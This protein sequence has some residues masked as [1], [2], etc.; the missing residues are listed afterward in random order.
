[1]ATLFL[2]LL[3]PFEA[4]LGDRPLG[5]FRSN[6][7]QALLIYLATEAEIVH[8]REALMALLWPGLPFKSA[9]V[10]LRQ[11]L[12]RLRQAIPELTA[13]DGQRTVP[14]LLTG[15]QTVHLNPA[16]D[17]QLDLARFAELLTPPPTP[18][19]L[20]RAVALYRGDFIC[21][22]CLP[23]SAEFEKWSAARRNELRRR[24][25]GA[26][27]TLTTIH[28]EQRNYA[29]AQAAAQ[30]GIEIDALRE[31]AYRQ[32]MRALA[33][34]GQREA[35]LDQY[36]L[37][38]QRL[39][40]A[41]GVEPSAQTTALY[42]QLLNLSQPGLSRDELP[43]SRTPTAQVQRPEP[44]AQPPM[45]HDVRT[46]PLHNLPLQPTPFVGREEELTQIA[47]RLADPTCR[48]L[49]LVGP[50]GIG[51]TRLALQASQDLIEA[52]AHGVFVVSLATISTPDDL[53]AT[54]ASALD[55]PFYSEAD[56]RQQLLAYLREKEILLVL[57]N[58]EHL[59]RG[60][61]LLT[62][63]LQTAPRVKLLLTSRER[64]HLRWEWCFEVEGLAYP[65][66]ETIVEE[67]LEYYSAL[68]LFRLTARRIDPEFSFTAQDRPGVVRICRLVEGMPLG[69]ELAASW[70]RVRTCEQIADEIERNLNFL[71]TSLRNVPPRHQSARATFE[72]SWRMLSP[73]EQDLFMKLSVLRGFRREAAG[74][75]ADATRSMLRSL[76]DKSLLRFL[77]SGRYE[78]HELL[79]QYAEEKLAAL[80]HAQ[81]GAHDRHCAHYAAFLRRHEVALARAGAAETL[82]AIRSEIANIRSAWRWAVTHCR[83]EELEQ[84]LNGL[85]RYYL[86]AGPFQEGE[87]LIGMAADCVRRLV[88]TA[89]KP[90]R[91]VHVV[92]SKLLKEQARLLNSQGTY[93]QAIVVARE[94]IDRA[95]ASGAVGLE[96]AGHVQWGRALWC[97]GNHQAAQSRFE[98]ALGLTQ[99]ASTLENLQI[100]G[101]IESLQ[102]AKA[103][104]LRYLGNVF[105]YQ[106]DYARTRDCYQECLGIYREIGDRRGESRALNNLGAVYFFQGD[107]AGAREYWEQ[108][109][110]IFREIGDRPGQGIALVNLGLLYHHLSDDRTALEY[111]RRAFTIRQEIGDL[112]GQGYALTVLGHALAGLGQWAE[113]ADVYQDALEI[114][115]ELGQ[116][117]LALESLAGLAR[118]SLAQ[119]E[120]AQAQAQ[121][122]QILDHLQTGD[123]RGAEEPFRVYLTCY[124]V[125]CAT[126]DPRA[127]AVLDTAHRLLQEWAARISDAAMSHSFLENVAAHREIVQAFQA[128]G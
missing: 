1:M 122:E 121:V 84:G 62:E 47:D 83:L 70:V 16:A 37:C 82:D 110:H 45:E 12:Y 59:V 53:V 107:Y 14:L 68:H 87:T 115:R 109:P 117:N 103:T 15:R 61:G 23:D 100:E 5:K 17:V 99:R 41:L 58:L 120:L 81:T 13:Q 54:I 92:L 108:S 40:A 126:G 38:H 111:G 119:R 26:L 113:A 80:P 95:Q 48:L 39:Q 42:E 74:E 89:D 29:Q 67:E 71:T 28:I 21:D 49:T 79:R 11:T 86:L 35:A 57:D 18:A 123:L 50:G 33:L 30:R 97:Q 102:A 19:H 116:H 105:M 76:V 2:S 55:F 94:A 22:F 51:K 75:V 46:R 112:A 7:A 3:G 10:N 98:T 93:E 25:L 34:D 101:S 36:Q 78:I 73:S 9:Q 8:R 124:R 90:E 24:V 77:P 66:G 65:P 118:V 72:H 69:I 96:A 106:G 63:I 64:L 44:L 104:C 20:T 85:S 60:M 6:K 125:L 52:F 4:A 27:E 43:R 31:S 91:D 88:D 114:R 128:H 32:L 127:Q 56:P